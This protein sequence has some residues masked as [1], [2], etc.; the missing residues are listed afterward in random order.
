MHDQSW[1]ICTVPAAQG[2]GKRLEHFFTE[3]SAV[4]FLPISIGKLPIN[5]VRFEDFDV[6][7]FNN[8]TL[9]HRSDTFPSLMHNANVGP[10]EEM[11]WKS[12]GQD[13]LTLGNTSQDPLDVAA[14]QNPV[15]VIV[16]SDNGDLDVLGAQ[17]G[18]SNRLQWLQ[19]KG[20]KVLDI[21]I[22]LLK[23]CT[24]LEWYIRWVYSILYKAATCRQN[25]LTDKCKTIRCSQM[26]EQRT[27]ITEI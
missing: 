5:F 14:P 10:E 9:F 18:P 3:A 11:D 22:H 1:E 15:P 25:P 24:A 6:Q 27:A 21:V 17:I 13:L 19:D 23:F 4:E 26:A 12:N 8:V 2:L 20:S 16:Q 7:E